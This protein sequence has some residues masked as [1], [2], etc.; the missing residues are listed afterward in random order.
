[1]QDKRRIEY[2]DYAKAISIFMVLMCHRLLL[3]IHV[4]GFAM[5]AFFVI[6]GYTSKNSPDL[7]KY[8][9]RQ[10]KSLLVPYWVA[11][12]VYCVIDVI[13]A[14]VFEYSTWRIVV[15]GLATLVYG[16]SYNVPVIGE[17]GRF[18]RESSPQGNLEIPWL[19]DI[20]TPLNCPLWFLPVMFSGSLIFTIVVRYRN[21]SRLRD[22]LLI[23]ALIAAGAVEIIPGMIQLPYGIGRGFLAA[24]YM[25]IGR[26]FKEKDIFNKG[27]SI[28]KT[29][30][31]VAAAAGGI[32]LGTKGYMNGTWNSSYYGSGGALGLV[33]SFV[34]GLLLV[35]AGVMLCRMI[36]LSPFNKL[37]YVLGVIGRNTLPTYLWHL[38]LF[39]VA[40]LIAVFGFKWQVTPEP[41]FVEMFDG[42]HLLY[43]WIVLFV[44]WAVLVVVG[45]HKNIK[46]GKK[47]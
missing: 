28:V 25:L 34:A 32:F 26:I 5:P 39:F 6:S 24:A 45:E 38:A 3:K 44:T 27:S 36:W 23:A 14:Y 18:I 2:F 31:S 40:D 9:K 43:R 46:T 12:A 35:Y 13:R 19:M 42:T 29:C 33:I 10:V 22:T 37:K 11:C 41:Y 7:R 8:V 21:E 30:I 17:L 20:M 47:E 4:L 16:S 15:P 1:M